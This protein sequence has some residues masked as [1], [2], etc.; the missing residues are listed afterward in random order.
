MLSEDSSCESYLRLSSFVF[1]EKKLT[2]QCFTNYVFLKGC[3]ECVSVR[4]LGHDGTSSDMC[5]NDCQKTPPSI[6]KRDVMGN[7]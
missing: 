3:G 7:M 4:L 2:C 1:K 5:K 6:F